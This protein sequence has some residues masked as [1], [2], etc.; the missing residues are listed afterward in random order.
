V[1]ETESKPEMFRK[2]MLLLILDFGL[3][4][5]VALNQQSAINNQK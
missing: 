1:S 5:E 2:S 4:I 3:R